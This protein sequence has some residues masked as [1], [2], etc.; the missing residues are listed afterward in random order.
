VSRRRQG[1]NRLVE[2]FRGSIKQ[3]LNS[4]PGYLSPRGSISAVR[5]I[6]VAKMSCF[7]GLKAEM[8][9]RDAQINGENFDNQIRKQQGHR[10][11]P[12]NIKSPTD[13]SLFKHWNHGFNLHFGHGYMY[14]LFIHGLYY[15]VPVE[16]LGQI[17]HPSD[18]RTNRLYYPNSFGSRTLGGNLSKSHTAV[19]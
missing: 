11:Q 19:K 16:A 8:V 1:A 9:R 14:D 18:N 4:L 7:V 17:C 13:Y 12:L 15:P 3:L 6:T 2:T 10:K 5:K